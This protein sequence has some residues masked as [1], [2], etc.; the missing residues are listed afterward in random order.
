M[1]DEQAMVNLLGSLF[2]DATNYSL[3]QSKLSAIDEQTNQTIIAKNQAEEKKAFLNMQD[4]DLKEKK[5]AN[6]TKIKDFM[7][8][9]DLYELNTSDWASLN[10][11]FQSEDGEKLLESL[12]LEMGEDFALS[13]QFSDN[14][15]ISIDRNKNLINIQDIIINH[16]SDVSDNLNKLNRDVK[17]IHDAGL[18]KGALDLHD[19]TREINQNP[20]KYARL[21]NDG[22]PIYSEQYKEILQYNEANPNN[23]ITNIDPTTMLYEP[24]Y[25]AIA[26]MGSKNI[27]DG[28]Q[29]G[30]LDE[31]KVDS[32]IK[33]QITASKK[34]GKTSAT[35][36]KESEKN[37][38]ELAVEN[39][40]RRIDQKEDLL[41]TTDGNLENT[42]YLSGAGGKT[43]A[44][45]YKVDNATGSKEYKT[46]LMI[47]IANTIDWGAERRLSST[48]GTI[49]KLV[50]TIKTST[51]A[52]T[53]EAAMR[54]LAVEL[55]GGNKGEGWETTLWNNAEMADIDLKSGWQSQDTEEN[56]LADKVDLWMQIDKRF[57]ELNFGSVKAG[58]NYAVANDPTLTMDQHIA[59]YVENNKE[60]LL[61][62]DVDTELDLNNMPYINEWANYNPSLGD[63]ILE[64]KANVSSGGV[65]PADI[66]SGLE[67]YTVPLSR[68]TKNAGNNSIVNN[69]IAAGA[70][71]QATNAFPQE[72]N[73]IANFIKDASL[74]QDIPGLTDMSNQLTAELDSLKNNAIIDTTNNAIIGFETGLQKDPLTGN[75]FQDTLSVDEFNE[76]Q[77]KLNITLNLLDAAREAENQLKK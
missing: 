60:R 34:S 16:M 28:K 30:W 13:T 9:F 20:N 73:I 54:Q 67:N 77:D 55:R 75:M 19:F 44:L 40:A 72:A 53:Q 23:P 38:W 4:D 50:N 63:A 35:A 31:T 76:K 15:D 71:N 70:I 3:N 24:N 39:I 51:N 66:R 69:T 11:Q 14:L 57:P 27:V 49:N 12:G 52:D 33:E 61:R 18:V 56:I 29:Y 41:S 46:S 68:Y 7:K 59:N 74:I 17:N 22:N 8:E 58:F 48:D 25:M 26:M 65:N 64:N 1:S 42:D 2:E 6:E 10:D 5:A 21:D 47:S 62:Y 43:S 45:G 32:L 37:N 36:I